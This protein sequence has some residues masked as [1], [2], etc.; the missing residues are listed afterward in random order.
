MA[1]IDKVAARRTVGRPGF[2]K[3]GTAYLPG[4]LATVAALALADQALVNVLRVVAPVVARHLRALVL[5]E[6]ELFA[7]L[8]RRRL[9]AQGHAHV[10]GLGDRADRGRGPERVVAPGSAPDHVAVGAARVGASSGTGVGNAPAIGAAVRLGGL[11]GTCEERNYKGLHASPSNIT[12]DYPPIKRDCP[13]SLL[14]LQ[15]RSLTPLEL[16][17]VPGVLW[18]VQDFGDVP[19]RE[20]ADDSY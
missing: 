8:G 12:R 16:Q 19:V 14:I 3:D 18:V 5:V 2:G 9:V 11:R 17:E 6:I 10:A 15:G 1:A 7:A 20:I 13:R 4:V